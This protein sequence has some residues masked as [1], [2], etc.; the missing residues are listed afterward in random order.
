MEGKKLDMANNYS[1]ELNEIWNK[2]D[3][4]RKNRV[5]ELSNLKSDGFLGTN[6]DQLEH[7]IKELLYKIENGEQSILEELL[8][9]KA[10]DK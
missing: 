10:R 9:T 1:F 3:Q 8:R 7:M 6:A 4:L 2:L 5:Y